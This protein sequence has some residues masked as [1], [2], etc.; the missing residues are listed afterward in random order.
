[1]FTV[2]FFF[3]YN[4]CLFSI[5]RIPTY[6]DKCMR[7]W[8]EDCKIE[9]IAGRCEKSKKDGCK[10]P[11][12]LLQ[13]LQGKASGCLIHFGVNIYLH[14]LYKDP[15]GIGVGHRALYEPSDSRYK[16]ALAAAEKATKERAAR[17]D[18]QLKAAEDAKKKADAEQ[19]TKNIRVAT[20]PLVPKK[21]RIQNLL[22]EIKEVYDVDEDELDEETKEMITSM[23][24]EMIGKKTSKSSTATK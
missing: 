24:A 22:K 23:L 5:M 1:M 4:V 18:L 11:H 16:E 2:F 3:S 10:G 21:A 8:W 20:K 9:E 14:H 13:H 7:P 6:S 15:Y 19:P 17:I 12:G